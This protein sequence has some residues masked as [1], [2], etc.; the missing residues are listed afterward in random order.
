MV[1]EIWLNKQSNLTFLIFAQARVAT[2]DVLSSW[3]QHS[4]AQIL[5]CISWNRESFDE[6][7]GISTAIAQ[8]NKLCKY[9]TH[10]MPSSRGIEGSSPF[11]YLGLLNWKYC[12]KYFACLARRQR[13]RWLRQ[14]QQHIV[15]PF[16]FKCK[17]AFW[18]FDEPM[19]KS[20]A[21]TTPKPKPKPNSPRLYLDLC[22]LINCG[23]T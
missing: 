21:A 15:G 4:R 2:K 12:F 11:I 19:P 13:W 1:H 23:Y 18:L 7:H 9:A 5:V 6:V 3:A 17:L 20:A 16:P 14:H 8:L 10:G 22:G